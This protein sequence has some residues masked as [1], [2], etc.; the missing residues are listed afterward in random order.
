MRYY[1]FVIG[2]TSTVGAINTDIVLHQ[3]ENGDASQLSSGARFVVF[4]PWCISIYLL[5]DK[6]SV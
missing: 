3:C 5:G 2:A 6:L 4:S 1:T